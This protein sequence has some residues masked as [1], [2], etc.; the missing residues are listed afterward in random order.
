MCETLFVQPSR[1]SATWM[2][3]A[4]VH[5]QDKV[6]RELI[7]EIGLL[8]T[9]SHLHLVILQTLLS[10]ATYNWGI[11]KA[12]NLEEANK[13]RKCPKTPSLRHCSN[14]YKLAREGEKDIEKWRDRREGIFLIFYFFYKLDKSTRIVKKRIIHKHR[15]IKRKLWIRKYIIMWGKIPALLVMRYLL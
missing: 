5:V 11:H 6:K 14:K 9:F 15:V 13:Q 3:T 7:M 1:A 2:L 10:K 12:I 4:V 8:I